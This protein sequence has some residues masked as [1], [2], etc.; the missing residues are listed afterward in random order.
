MGKG[1]G[2]TFGVLLAIF[3]LFNINN[4]YQNKKADQNQKS[5]AELNNLEKWSDG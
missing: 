1:A 5:D 2:A 3:I 4:Y